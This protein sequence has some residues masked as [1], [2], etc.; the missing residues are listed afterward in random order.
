MRTRLKICCISSRAEAVIAGDAGASAL[1]LVS[2]MPS[3]PGVISESLI[4]DIAACIPVGIAAVLLTSLRRAP[5][6]I[7]QQHRCRADVL[8]LCEVVPHDDLRRL[9]DALP[10]T[11]LM[12]VVHVD[13]EGSIV[14]AEGMAPYVDALLLDTGSRT[15]AVRELGGTGRT[16]DWSISARIVAATDRPTFLAGGL[17]ADNVAL[18]IET[19]RPYGVDVCSGVRVN[20]HLHHDRLEAFAAAVAE[21]GAR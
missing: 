5:D 3:G 15:G 16:H 13:G 19:V 21:A 11:R 6:L 18:A 4:A 10:G 1:G 14:E 9:R 12:H 8:Q 7:A 17:T 2:M 20:G